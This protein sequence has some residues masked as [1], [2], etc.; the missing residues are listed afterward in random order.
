GGNGEKRF[1]DG[2]RSPLCN[3]H[4]K[5]KAPEASTACASVWSQMARPSGFNTALL[6]PIYQMS[7]ADSQLLLGARG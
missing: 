7:P 4:F 6:G 5:G 1:G 2:E 3:L